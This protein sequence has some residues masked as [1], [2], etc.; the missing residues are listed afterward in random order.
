MGFFS[1]IKK[2]FGGATED[3]ASAEAQ[4]SAV[5]AETPAGGDAAPEA[6]APSTPAAPA[7]EMSA[8]PSLAAEPEGEALTLRLREAEPRLS[9]WLGIV[10]EGVDEAGDL[11]WRRLSFLLRA[12]DAPEA[13]A[14]A[15]V[16]DFQAWLGRMNL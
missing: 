3:A 6:T 10:L 14:K 12:L 15:F 2:M 8:A 4:S 1:A 16:D 7:P 9:V 13:E 5:Q 11:L